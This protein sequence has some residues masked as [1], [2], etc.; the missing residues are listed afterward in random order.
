MSKVSVSDI[1]RWFGVPEGLLALPR[2]TSREELIAR[3]E[4]KLES[5]QFSGAVCDNADFIADLESDLRACVEE[6]KQ[7]ERLMSKRKP[8][9]PRRY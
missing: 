4:S 2:L 9:K 5:M 8:K 7:K 6:L 3:L 1:A